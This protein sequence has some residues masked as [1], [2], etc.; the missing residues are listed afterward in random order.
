MHLEHRAIAASG[1]PGARELIIKIL[2]ASS[3]IPAVFPPQMFDVEVNG[4]HRQ[5]MHADG[6]V[7]AQAFLYPPNIDFQEA[8]KLGGIAPPAGRLHH[9]QWPVAGKPVHRRSK[10]AEHRRAGGLVDDLQQRHQRHVRI[11]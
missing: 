6:G 1:R 4:E 9:P 8:A 11:T 10:D 3:A 7:F 2:M 5:E